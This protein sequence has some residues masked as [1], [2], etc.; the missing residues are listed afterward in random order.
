LGYAYAR[1]GRRDEATKIIDELRQR[2]KSE[3]I[4]PYDVAI[5]Y[6]GLGDTE[7]AIEQLEKAYDDRAGW[8]IYLNVEPMLD[9]IRSDPRFTALL[10]RMKLQS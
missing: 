7:N 4:S 3:Y 8:M 2:S 9:P 1:A 5:I 10:H 6:V